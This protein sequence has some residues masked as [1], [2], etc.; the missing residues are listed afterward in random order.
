MEN[1]YTS[2]LLSH[3]SQNSPGSSKLSLETE[4]THKNLF[5]KQLCPW[6][7]ER[8]GTCHKLQMVLFFFFWHFVLLPIFL[9]RPN[10]WYLFCSS[11]K[12]FYAYLSYNVLLIDLW[13]FLWHWI[14]YIYIFSL[15]LS[16]SIQI[17]IC[18][19]IS[20]PLPLF[21]SFIS[22]TFIVVYLFV[23][24]WVCATVFCIAF[25]TQ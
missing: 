7:I 10:L 11:V 13:S 3:S 25:L 14:Y 17:C 9:N 18:M 24:L 22:I 15:F 16:V 5:K 2:A 23:C 20:L 1:L 4:S 21:L 12:Y 8:R 19:Q 6:Q